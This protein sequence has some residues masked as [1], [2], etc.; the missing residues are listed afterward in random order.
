MERPQNPTRREFVKTAGA[1]LAVPYV[2]TSAA[3]GNADRPAASERIVMGGIGLGNMGSGD[4]GAFLGRPDVQYIA[5]SDVRRRVC[6]AAKN[7]A[8]KR[9]KNSDCQAYNDFR[10]L[11][12]RTD[13]DAVHIATPDHWH[14]IMVI[15]LL[16]TSPRKLATRQCM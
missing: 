12:A 16:Y 11:L 4:Q 14:A 2:I 10:E 1:A 6:E 7:R 8:D 3:L 5:V 13:I 9:Y 15:C